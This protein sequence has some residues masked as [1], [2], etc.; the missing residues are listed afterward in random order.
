MTAMASRARNDLM[1]MCADT[2]A[3]DLGDSSP[4]GVVHAGTLL[5]GTHELVR[6]FPHHFVEVDIAT[7]EGRVIS[8]PH[9]RAAAEGLGASGT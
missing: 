5:R 1:Y 9:G 7:L 6:R 4:T 8:L 3:G 2:F